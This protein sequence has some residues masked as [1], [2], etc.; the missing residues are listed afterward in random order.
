MSYENLLQEWYRIKQD[1]SRLHSQE[2]ELKEELHRIMNAKN[3]NKIA[4]HN[5]ICSR[6]VRTSR[7]ILKNSIP[8]DIWMEYSTSNRYPVLTLKK[9]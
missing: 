6:T 9:I 7:T 1:M 8:D 2:K 5:F 4:T 3:V